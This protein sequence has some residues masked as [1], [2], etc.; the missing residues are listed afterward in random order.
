[1]AHEP[2]KDKGDTITE[3]MKEREEYLRKRERETHGT[4]PFSF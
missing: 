3:E 2:K 4:F 1:M